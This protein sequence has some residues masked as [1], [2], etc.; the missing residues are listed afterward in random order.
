MEKY[1]VTAIKNGTKKTIAVMA[2]CHEQHIWSKTK[3]VGVSAAGIKKL[4]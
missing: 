4:D 1:K 3:L 2:D